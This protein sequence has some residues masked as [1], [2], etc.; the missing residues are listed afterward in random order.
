MTRFVSPKLFVLALAALG[1]GT[2]FAQ[3]GNPPTPAG[4]GDYHHDRDDEDDGGVIAV[5]K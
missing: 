5:G 1:A 2:S 4:W 3:Y